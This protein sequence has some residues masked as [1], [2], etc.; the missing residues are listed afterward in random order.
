[1]RRS[2]N[3]Q[4]HGSSLSDFQEYSFKRKVEKALT[5]VKAV[6]DTSRNPTLPADV[7][8]GYDDKYSLAESAGRTAVAAQMNTLAMLGLDEEKLACLLEWSRA[9]RM[10]TLK[11]TCSETCKHARTEE[12]EEDTGV[13]RVTESDSAFFGSSK[14][15]HKTIV[16][17]I[18]HFWTVQAEWAI[19][20]F[21]GGA[22]TPENKPI[23]LLSRKGTCELKTQ[24][25]TKSPPKPETTIHPPIELQFDF[26]LSCFDGDG[27]IK[28]VID[29][30]ASDCHTPRRNKQAEDARQWFTDLY[31][32][33]TSVR[34]SL[35]RMSSTDPAFAQKQS[36]F[37]NNSKELF[38]PILAMFSLEEGQAEGTGAGAGGA[39]LVL[40]ATD[41][42]AFIGEHLK[43]LEVQRDELAKIFPAADAAAKAD[44]DADADAGADGSGGSSTETLVTTREAGAMASLNALAT[45]CQDG[46]DAFDAIEGMLYSQLRDAIGKEITPQDFSEYMAFHNRR[47]FKEEYRPQGFCYAIRRPAHFPEG[48]LSIS[49][50][51]GSG[52]GGGSSSDSTP[53][54]TTLV[55]HAV[56]PK[57]GDGGDSGDGGT[58][59]MRFAL[60]AAT[61]V[62]FAGDRFLHASVMH[63]FS[64]SAPAPLQLEAKARQ[65]SSFVL[66]VGRIAA[67]DV[68]EPTAAIIVKDKDDLKIPLMLE[69]IPTPKEFRDAIESLSPEQQRFCKAFRSMQLASTLFGVLVI[70][71]KPALERL[72]NLP[73]DSLTKEIR[74]TQDLMELFIEHQIPSDLISYGAAGADAA[75]EGHTPAEK[76]E[77]VKGHVKALKEVI[78]AEKKVELEQAELGAAKAKAERQRV[79]MEEEQML[80]MSLGMAEESMEVR[81]Q[82]N[83]LSMDAA[84]FSAPMKSA[85]RG[86]GGMLKRSAAAAPAMAM[87]TKAAVGSAMP[88]AA[89]ARSGMSGA[90]RNS[91][92]G[93]AHRASRG[94]GGGGEGFVPPPAPATVGGMNMPVEQKAA[95]SSSPAQQQ[96]QPEGGASA[97]AGGAG[98]GASAVAIDYTKIPSEL[99]RRYEALDEDSALRPTTIKTG[100]VW[101]LKSQAGLLSK[102]VEKMVSAE[103]QKERKAQAFDLLDALSRSG[104]LPLEHASLHIVIAATHCFDQSLVDT[105]I[106]GNV[107]P[108]EKAERSTLIVAGVIH[109]M[110][111]AKMLKDG[112]QVDRIAQFSPGL[113]LE[114]GAEDEGS[115]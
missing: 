6:L 88:A 77:A 59:M 62:S 58:P 113:L 37:H 20:A 41:Q 65:F 92:G 55:S 25:K 100:E 13:K 33:A 85:R 5:R 99:D 22:S 74:L 44:A 76:L 105:V 89:P 112:A 10:V 83:D 48:T 96:Q 79:R 57:G 53:Q 97:G 1:M 8:H 42:R 4:H 46:A 108:V 78:D 47:L 28:F 24:G 7:P 73:D 52:S 51:S 106:Q 81:A 12:R 15:T 61:E 17:V 95:S 18:E 39:E 34:Q 84:S 2:P 94:G 50:A 56:A 40:S 45:L 11:F 63:T 101:R 115:A 36:Y 35:D 43:Q 69:T 87:A 29:R 72:L 90:A 38:S 71:I 30:G 21:A 109:R 110:P 32:W 14:T 54:L 16:K 27:S 75:A 31:S 23:V 19:T 91:L 82:L 107:N 3:R 26:P 9:Q 67:A 86:W 93:A 66:L 64:Q 60:N 114:E 98:A 49:Q 70:Q 102:P 80:E 111:T 104:E 68:F 103:A